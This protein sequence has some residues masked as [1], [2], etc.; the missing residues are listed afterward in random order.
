MEA[1]RELRRPKVEINR[2]ETTGVVRGYPKV[3]RGYP[4]IADG[5]HRW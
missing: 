1:V 2:E 4:K 5:E 3:V